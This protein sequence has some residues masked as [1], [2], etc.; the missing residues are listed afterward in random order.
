MLIQD[1]ERLYNELMRKIDEIAHEP[2]FFKQ[3]QK[4]AELGDFLG[5][6]YDSGYSDGYNTG[7]EIGL[8]H[9]IDELTKK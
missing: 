8:K 7:Y 5:S 2:S 9:S 4:A 6:I 3:T 1:K